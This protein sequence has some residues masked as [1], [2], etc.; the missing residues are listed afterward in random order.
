MEI[1]QKHL[2]SLVSS[3]KWTT[4]GYEK[5]THMHSYHVY[6]MTITVMVT[7]RGFNWIARAHVEGLGLLGAFVGTLEG[8]SKECRLEAAIKAVESMPSG[9]EILE[10]LD[11]NE[12]EEVTDKFSA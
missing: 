10:M 11:G 2:Y 5:R 8:Q 1:S 12:G 6:G 3:E 4:T 7:K 9:I